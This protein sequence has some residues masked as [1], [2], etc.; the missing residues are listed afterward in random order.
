MRL[1]LLNQRCLILP[2]SAEIKE[3]DRTVHFLKNSGL[4]KQKS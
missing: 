2:K 3:K 4:E 1:G